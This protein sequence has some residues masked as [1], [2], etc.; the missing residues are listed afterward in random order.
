M[1]QAHYKCFANQNVCL[2]PAPKTMRDHFILLDDK[3]EN[4]SHI[5]LDFHLRI[6]Y[7]RDLME[8]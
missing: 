7:G 4:Y 1:L 3:G 5:T 6:K 8:L 2:D